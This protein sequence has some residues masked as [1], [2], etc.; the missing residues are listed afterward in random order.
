MLNVG[1]IGAGLIGKKRAG[2]L[3]SGMNLVGAFDPNQAIYEQFRLQFPS[4][5]FD[6]ASHLIENVGAGGLVLV[7]T[8]HN[9]LAPIAK[10]ALQAG[11][12]VL[13]EKPGALNLAELKELKFEAEK[14]NRI[15]R[16]GYNHRFHPGLLKLKD[17]VKNGAY[18]DVQLIRARYGHGGRLGYENEWRAQREVSGGGELID[19]G[20]HLI[21]LSHFLVGSSTLDFASLPTIYW[22]MEVED[23]A[24]LALSTARGA[25]SWLHASW[26]EWKNLFSFEVFFKTAKVEVSGLG[27][28]YGPEKLI[29]HHMEQGLGI[30]ATKEETFGE[31]DSSWAL[32]MS[33]ITSQINGLEHSGADIYSAIDVFEIIESAY[34]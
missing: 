23:N 8:P 32:E 7:C 29:V 4:N 25:K 2:S 12:H 16:I 3:T 31:S 13:I 34:K 27:G 26:T 33:D 6:N 11:C 21:D 22:N 9:L 5:V 14:A 20:S 19:Q 10:L 28:S 18:G 15:V 30:P 17:I 24:F 1:I